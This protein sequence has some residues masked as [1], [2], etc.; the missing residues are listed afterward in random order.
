MSFQIK[1]IVLYGRN[2]QVRIVT[3]K[4]NSV[5]IITGASRTGKSSLIHIVK[6]CLGAKKSDI[7]IRGEILDKIGWFGILI[8]R[9]E[10]ELFVARRNPERG[11]LS[12]EDIYIEKGRNLDIASQESL[13][14]NINRDGL[15]TLLTEFAGI[16]EYA[17]EPGEG[18]T[19]Y[20]GKADIGKSLIYCFQQ[21][22]EIDNPDFLFHRQ[23]EPYLPQSIKDYMPF[24]L[25]AVGKDYVL[26]K[27]EL[28]QRKRDLRRLEKRKAENGILRESSFERA[29]ALVAEAVSV[30]LLPNERAMPQ[31]WLEVKE[32]LFAA[33]K[34]QNEYCIPEDE[35]GLELNRLLDR[36]KELRNE[37]RLRSDE[38]DAL[39]ALKSSGN[40]FIHEAAEHRARLSSIE[41]IP[42]VEESNQNICPF[43]SSLLDN[44]VPDAD[45]IRSN[46]QN[47]SARLEGVSLDL[48][49]LEEIIVMTKSSLE[50]ITLELR[51]INSQIRAIQKVNLDS[52]DISETN[53]KQAHVK[54]RIGFYLDTLVD[55]EDIMVESREAEELR[56]QIQALEDILNTEVLRDHLDSILSRISKDIT[57]M[58]QILTL[59]YSEC[60]MRL[61]SKKL[62]VVADTEDGPR[63]LKRMGSG[64]TWVSLH[65]IT[66]L[67]LH[68][69]FAKK[70]LPVPHF[71]FFDQPTQ[72][73]FPGET[74]QAVKQNSDKE[75]VVRMFRLILDWVKDTGFQVI[76]LEHAD[77]QQD[78]YQ[79]LIVEKWWDG[80]NKLVPQSWI[81]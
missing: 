18:Q 2:G 34:N 20:P 75:A 38:I 72:G 55:A 42:V 44:P 57:E 28:N 29:H 12:S 50:N 78:W 81:D 58:S 53:E 47:V 68:R 49:H 37:S 24:F 45:A 7:T 10:E 71:I 30:G 48:P 13:T 22:N 36:Q 51:D 23:G 77:I 11:R 80:D 69:W 21:Q 67:A 25:G 6:Y 63:P 62:T 39:K 26:H 56:R 33:T 59:E 9:E 17:F 35:Y 43:C 66:H 1:K 31:S 3:L 19:R 4:T 54:G 46:L 8:V 27:E 52:E 40:G 32:V 5:N 79:E 74:D 15:V 70:V 60:P 61:D 76:I 16:A 64:E 73:Y 14:Q 41:L 65:V